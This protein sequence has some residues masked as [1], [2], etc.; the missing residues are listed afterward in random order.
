M[1]LYRHLPTSLICAA[2][3]GACGG[4]D[5]S[6]PITDDTILGIA[7][8]SAGFYFYPPWGVMTTA[9]R[10]WAPDAYAHLTIR[11]DE[12][13]TATGQIRRNIRTFSPLTTPRISRHY[14]YQAFALN[15]DLT[16]D[17]FTDGT[18]V[19]ATIFADGREL[20]RSD[21]P[22]Q[23]IPVLRARPDMWLKF[24]VERAAVDRDL[25]GIDDW[26]DRC[27]ELA[28]PENRCLVPVLFPASTVLVARACPS[29]WGDLGLTGNG[30][31]SANCGT[32]MCHLC[33]SPSAP[34]PVPAGM[35]AVMNA[36]PASWTD[37]GT[38][39][40]GPG[41]IGCVSSV[42]CRLCESSATSVLSSGA[43][44]VAQSCPASWTDEGTTTPAGPLRA[45]C[46][47][48]DCRRCTVP[49]L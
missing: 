10:D 12:T 29:G 20:G 26:N 31:A 8:T 30:P 13:D 22:P 18:T 42:S 28:D 41:A 14:D 3:L 27:P 17:T 34:S 2:L 24:R 45:A 7:T 23:Y 25:D 16:R 37:V 32:A 44:F 39:P 5:D 36:C 19:R 21:I 49:A 11:I 35:V 40:G 46:P 33:Q 15:W 38:P 1:K 43:S 9:P 4:S 6:S 48:A 47:T